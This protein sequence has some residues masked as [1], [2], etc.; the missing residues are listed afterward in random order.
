M[1]G[2]V[3]EL[4]ALEGDEAQVRR[5]TEAVNAGWTTKYL[6]T[7]SIP[8]RQIDVKRAWDRERELG[9]V[10]FA[11][12]NKDWF[13]GTCGLYAKREIYRS[14]EF[15]I[16]IFDPHAIGK[17]AGT[18]ATNLTVGYGFERLNAHRIWL[19]VNAENVGAIKCYLK[20]GFKEEGRLRD[21]LFIHG[22]YVDAI[23]M[24]LLESE[25]KAKQECHIER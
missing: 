8:M 14:W 16:I 18:E 7:G 2:S 24:G 19:G 5:Y 1:R 10:E 23:R 6:F 3:C 25:W 20:C 22:K 9:S 4:H 15:R 13:I 12:Y 11:V 17:G 21:E